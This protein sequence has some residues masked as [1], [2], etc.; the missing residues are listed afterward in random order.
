LKETPSEAELVSHKLMLRAGFIRRLAAG[1]Y[2]FLPL[3]YRVIKK[4]ETIIREE[5]D[6]SGALEVFLPVLS[7]SELWQESERLN[8]YGP[9]LMRISDRHNRSFCLGPTH[10]EVI[11]DLVRSDVRSYRQLPL[12]LYQIQTK[13]RDEIRPRFGVM[14]AREFLMKD[15]YSFDRDMD[16]ARKTYRAM[17]EAYES[18]FRRC[19]LEYRAVEADSGPIGGDVSQ[20]F[21]VLA[22][23]GEDKIAVCDS[24]RYAANL[25]RAQS[26]KPKPSE[27]PPSPE[28]IRKVHTPDIHTVEQ[29]STFLKCRPEDLVKTL[30]IKAIYGQE[31]K[32]FAV[33]IRGDHELN[34][35]KLK[36]F[37]RCDTL[38]M[39]DAE[40]VERVTAAPVGFAGPIGLKDIPILADKTIRSMVNFV[41]GANLADYH[42]IKVNRDRD[43]EVAP[44]NFGDFVNVC[45]GDQC[46]HCEGKVRLLRGIEVGHIFIL[47][48][49]Y[50][51][52]LSCNFLDEQGKE[53]PM[54]MGCYGIGVGRTAAASIE[55][56]HDEN[57]IIWPYSIAPFQ[58]MILPLDMKNAEVLNLAESLYKTLTSEGVEVLLDDRDERPGAKFKDADLIGIPLRITI[59]ARDLKKN[60]VEIKERKTGA[61]EKVASEKILEAIRGKISKFRNNNR[62]IPY[63][64]EE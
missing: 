20:E 14:R 62:S 46:L 40:I 15:G 19:G 11:T 32:I 43:F 42:Y 21:M 63:R 6:K 3:G 23:S 45:Q 8:Q 57:G 10:E 12:N 25:E 28:P 59:G 48:T 29:V 39:A 16:G 4:I 61:V 51:S 31:E 55:Q 30:V 24:C 7:P 26:R 13:F 53:N 56:N 1:V 17:N 58:V 47:G 2:S 38:E 50:S 22:D 44:E 35:T 60:M 5:M 49:K 41:T 9:E 54:V 18:I 64:H 33:L 27:N 37:L 34:E 36:N 52:A